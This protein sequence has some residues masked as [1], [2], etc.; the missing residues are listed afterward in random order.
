MICAII[1]KDIVYKIRID[2]GWSVNR[3]ASE[4]M[5]T[6]STVSNMFNSHAEPKLSTLRAI[7]DAFDMSMSEFFKRTA[8]K[9]S[10][11]AL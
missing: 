4:A 11:P 8:L 9:K 1:N 2:K 10:T 3:L 6:Q 7:L 5:L